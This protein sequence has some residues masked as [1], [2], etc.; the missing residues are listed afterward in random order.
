MACTAATAT[1][2]TGAADP[3]G[4]CVPCRDR[5]HAGRQGRPG[6]HDQGGRRR[7]RSPTNTFGQ[8]IGARSARDLIVI[9]PLP[10]SSL[11]SVTPKLMT[12]AAGVVNML[13]G[14][15]RP[16]VATLMLLLLVLT[17]CTH[18][19]KPVPPPVTLRYV[20]P[21]GSPFQGVP[22]TV[23]NPGYSAG[24]DQPLPPANQTVSLTC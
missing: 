13:A 21:N 14:K 4:W 15:T 22:A 8:L 2:T 23:K 10:Y 5:Y 12:R 16:V 9:A 1:D 17:A 24:Q 6:A 19:A 3:R 20:F 18:A 11:M 7:S